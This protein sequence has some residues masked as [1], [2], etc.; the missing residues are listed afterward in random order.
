MSKVVVVDVAADPKRARYGGRCGQP[1]CAQERRFSTCV[2]DARTL[3]CPSSVSSGSSATAVC[4]PL[5]GSTPIITSATMSSSER[6]GP[7]R[8]CPVSDRPAFS[9]LVSPATVRSDERAPRA[10]AR[11]TVG[12]RFASQPVAPLRRYDRSRTPSPVSI[13]R[14]WCGRTIGGWL[15]P[16]RAGGYWSLALPDSCGCGTSMSNGRGR[17]G[18]RMQAAVDV[19]SA[20]AQRGC[21]GTSRRGS[22]SR[23]LPADSHACAIAKR[24]RTQSKKLIEHPFGAQIRR[25]RHHGVDQWPATPAAAPSGS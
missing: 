24:V 20:A 25:R 18:G 8:A 17:A 15:S 12:R 22:S 14:I 3:I 23:P 10:K 7:W 4:D 5:C 21:N 13:R 16:C 9:P 2:D 19:L 11:Q 6:D 1:L